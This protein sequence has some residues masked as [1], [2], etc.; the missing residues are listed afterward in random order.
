MKT[1]VLSAKWEP[2]PGDKVSEFE[3]RTGKSGEV[4]SVWRHPKLELRDWPQPKPG[5][6]EVL[7]RVGACGVYDFDVHLH[8]AEGNGYMIYPA[9]QIFPPSLATSSL[10]KL[11]TS[12]LA[13]RLRA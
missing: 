5:Q 1:L 2:R 3:K 7:V 8:E 6:G 11:W 9:S 10:D 12:A 4:S 13:P